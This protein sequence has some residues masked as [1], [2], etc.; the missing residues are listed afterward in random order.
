LDLFLATFGSHFWII[1]GAKT[2]SK[3]CFFCK[4]PAGPCKAFWDAS[5][6]SW[7]SLGKAGVPKVLQKTMQTDD[8]QNRSFSLSQLLWMAFGGNFG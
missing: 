6:P 1:F 5:W 3:R 2:M 7:G 4:V 8:F